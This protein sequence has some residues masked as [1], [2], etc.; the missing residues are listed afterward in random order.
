MISSRT[1]PINIVTNLQPCPGME[2]SLLEYSKWRKAK[3]PVKASGSKKPKSSSS[4]AHSSQPTHDIPDPD[5]E[6]EDIDDMLGPEL[7]DAIDKL[8]QLL[9]GLDSEKDG[10]EF[11]DGEEMELDDVDEGPGREFFESTDESE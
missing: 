9:A 1:S 10:A 4:R 8:S 3:K 6:A 11:A 7:R 2:T 5:P